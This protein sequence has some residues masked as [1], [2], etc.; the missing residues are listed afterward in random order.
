MI[1]HSQ[2]PYNAEPELG[3]LRAGMITPQADFYVRSHGDTP[4]IDAARYRLLVAGLVSRPL[5]LGLET[6]R[7]RFAER[8][9]VAAMQC[10]G[11]RRADMQEAGKTSGDPWAAG[12]IGNAV[13]TGVALADVLR[14]AGVVEKRGMHVAFEALDV[15]EMPG[16][17][18]FT[19]G[20]SIP[21]AKAL[22][23]EVL[24]AYAMNGEALGRAHGF[25]LRVVVPG[26]AGVRSAKWLGA[27]TVQD[28]PSANHMQQRDYKLLPPDITE[29]SVDWDRGVTIDAMPLNSAICVPAAG[30]RIAAGRTRVLGHAVASGRDVVR[31]DVSA[32]GGCRWVQAALTRAADAPFGWVLWETALDLAAGERELV[33]RAW[34][35]AGQTQPALVR[36]VWNFKGYLSAAWHRVRVFAA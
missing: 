24:L 4:E 8:S 16:E 19:Y 29:E 9:V 17:G 22:C 10:A 3:R 26:Y 6:L 13:W 33:V 2:T 5:E 15:I 28:G 36:D 20:V 32:D 21:L 7:A 14:E 35:A 25:P 30:A 34:D 11:N 12:A 31:V 18:R 1:V 23:P 27:I